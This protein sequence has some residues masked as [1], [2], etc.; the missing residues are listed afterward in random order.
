MIRLIC[1]KIKELDPNF[2][3]ILKE[4]NLNPTILA[5]LQRCSLDANRDHRDNT[6]ITV[7]Y[8]EQCR[9][10][11]ARSIFF[12]QK[13]SGFMSLKSGFHCLD[14]RLVLHHLEGTP[15]F[16]IEKIIVAIFRPMTIKIIN[17]TLQLVV[18]FLLLD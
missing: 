6:D 3:M 11:Y 18:G 4:K 14:S 10:C 12:C 16:I 1:C 8:S 5:L 7:N 2:A 17:A 15:E 13:T 9:Q